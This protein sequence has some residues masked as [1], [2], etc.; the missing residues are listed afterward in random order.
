MYKYIII[1]TFAKI[2]IVGVE[3]KEYVAPEVWSATFKCERG[4]ATSD[5]DHTLSLT[6]PDGYSGNTASSYEHETWIW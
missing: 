3:K 2:T 6:P 4:Y 1:R 5:C